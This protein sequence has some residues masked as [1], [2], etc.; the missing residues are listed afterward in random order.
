MDK[1]QAFDETDIERLTEYML[2]VGLKRL[3]VGTLELELSETAISIALSKQIEATEFAPAKQ[4]DTEEKDTSKT[5][6]DTE[7]LSDKEY[8]ELLNWS[9]N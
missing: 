8:D 9:A 4:K 7:E 1:Q 2:E 3:K 6:V 5:M